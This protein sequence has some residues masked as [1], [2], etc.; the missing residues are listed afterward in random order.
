MNC[1]L[2]DFTPHDINV[3]VKNLNQTN[4]RKI[5]QKQNGSDSIF[6]FAVIADSH[7]AYDRLQEMVLHLNKQSDIDFL[8]IAGDVTKFGL[9]KEY[10]WLHTV[11][12]ML[13]IPYIVL[14]G[15]HDCQGNGKAIFKKMFGE[16]DDVFNYKNTKFVFANNNGWEFDSDVPNYNFLDTALTAPIAGNH[17]FYISHVPIFGD[18][19]SVANEKIL[20]QKINTNG[21]DLAIFGHKHNWTYKKWY[22]GDDLDYLLVDNVVDLN[23]AMIKVNGTSVKVTRE[24]VNE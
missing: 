14:L 16:F 2:F 13:N 24:W 20:R 19:V 22:E 8:I 6:N 15:N 5:L 9:I 3:K 12:K 1:D 17:L 21:V 7:R 4:Y 18:Q 11:L 10:N 23:Y